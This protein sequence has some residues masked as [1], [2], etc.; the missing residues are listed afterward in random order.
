MTFYYVITRWG[1][2]GHYSSKKKDRD[3][4][5]TN[6]SK[7]EKNTMDKTDNIKKKIFTI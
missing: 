6:E 7:N 2:C 3:N 1:K 4:K 5:V